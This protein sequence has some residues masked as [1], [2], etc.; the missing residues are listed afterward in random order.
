MVIMPYCGN[1]SSNVTVFS[2]LAAV[3]T[4]NTDYFHCGKYSVIMYNMTI[5]M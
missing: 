5:Y 4:Y 3:K 1:T 2:C